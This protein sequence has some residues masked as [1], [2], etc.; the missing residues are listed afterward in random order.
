GG[1]GD[2][3]SGGAPTPSQP[4]RG[5]AAAPHAALRAGAVAGGD[6]A[7]RGGG[8]SGD[9]SAGWTGRRG[10]GDR[11]GGLSSA[12]PRRLEEGGPGHAG[13][14]RPRDQAPLRV[15][16]GRVRGAGRDRS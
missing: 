2:L 15:L 8:R 10:G 3:G 16:V 9:E 6:R 12:P 4:R 14:T 13:A 5:A 7:G 11:A 1:E